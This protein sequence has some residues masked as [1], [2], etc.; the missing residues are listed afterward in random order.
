MAAVASLRETPGV[1]LKEIVAATDRPSWL[2]ESGVFPV[3]NW[4]KA[5]SGTMFSGE[6]LT[7]APVEGAPC[8]VL[9]IALLARLRA[10]S[11]VIC[12]VAPLAL[13]PCWPGGAIGEF[14]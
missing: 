10:V 8:L 11:P 12:L 2:T 7:A 14:W 6:V 4:A 3:S 13:L 9:A 5:E 1:R